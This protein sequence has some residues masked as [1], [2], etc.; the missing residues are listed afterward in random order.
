MNTVDHGA[1]TLIKELKPS[2]S[3]HFDHGIY[4]KGIAI[5]KKN[6]DYKSFKI[7]A[8]KC[9]EVVLRDFKYIKQ[10]LRKSSL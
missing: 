6:Y 3:C 2:K 10:K 8:L 7:M 5:E 4:T 9:V 1:N